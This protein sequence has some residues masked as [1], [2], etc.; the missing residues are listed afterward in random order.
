[1]VPVTVRAKIIPGSVA[2]SA[3]KITM[4]P[5][6]VK[7]GSIVTFVVTNTDPNAERVFE[8]DGRLTT[9]IPARG[10][11]ILR[12]VRF[13]KPGAYVA[14]C[15]GTAEGIGGVFTVTR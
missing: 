8:I 13:A 5:D 14:S 3:G 1:M 10:H 9:V 15:P 7:A 4:I 2:E 6:H 12:D 11:R